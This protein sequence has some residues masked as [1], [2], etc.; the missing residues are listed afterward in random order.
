MAVIHTEQFLEQ[1]QSS[2]QFTDLE[3]KRLTYTLK[4]V[5][6]ELIKTLLLS[7]LFYK[8]GYLPEFFIG[9]LILITIRCN[10]GGLHMEHFITCLFIYTLHL[11]CWRL[12][13]CRLLYRFHI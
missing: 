10:S 8:L 11:C 2:Y 6:S 4:A 5:S 12:L 13:Y 7:A 1:I 9:V 3:M